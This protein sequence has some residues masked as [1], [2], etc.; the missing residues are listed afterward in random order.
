[1]LESNDVVVVKTAMDLDLGHELL[2]G[3]R[4]CQRSLCNDLGGR[5]SLS[6]KVCEFIA[7]S[8]TSLA[9]ELTTKIFL[10]T[11][12]TVELDDFLFNNNLGGILLVL[13][14]LSCLL[15]LLHCFYL[16]ELVVRSYRALYFLIIRI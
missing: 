13:H 1:V 16:S 9:K 5:H 15:G 4:L 2:L 14:G 10:D 12:V 7:L 11:D 8:E 3:T 6:L